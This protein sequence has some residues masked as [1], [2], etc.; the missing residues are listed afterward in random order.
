MTAV[1]APTKKEWE[2]AEK[3]A[4]GKRKQTDS[5]EDDEEA[6]DEGAEGSRGRKKRKLVRAVET[7]FSQSKL[8]VHKGIN[9][10]FSDDQKIAITHQTLRAT[11]S[12]NLPERW[13]SD[14]K[15]MKLF[16][17][18]RSRAMDAIP[19]RSQLGGSLLEKAATKIDAK[20]A[21]QVKGQDV[22]MCTDGWRSNRRDTVGGVT[23]THKFK[24]LLI[25]ILRINQLRK[26]GESLKRQF[27]EMI[28]EAERKL[29]C[30]IIGF[31]TDND[32]GSK[33]AQTL[34]TAA[35]AWLLTFPCCAHQGQLILTDYLRENKEAEVLLGELIDFV[36]WLNSHD[37]IRALFDNKQQ[38]MFGKILA[39]LL[40]NLTCCT[41]HLIAAIRFEFLKAPIRAVILNQ[42]DDIIAAQSDHVRPDQF[43]LALAGLF[44]HF[45]GFSE[46]TTASER[47]LGQRMC[48]H[49]EKRFKELDQVVF[50]LALILNPFAKLSRF[51]DMA[52]ID[53]FKIATELITLFKHINS[54]PPKNPRTAAEQEE[55]DAKQKET[56]QTIN[57]AFMQYLSETGPF[58]SWF[59]KESPQRASYDSLHIC[60]DDPIPFWEMLQTNKA[61]RPLANFALQ[62]LHLVV[63]QAGLEHWFSDFLNKNNKKRN[64]LGLKKMGQQANVQR[65]LVF[66]LQVP[67]RRQVTRYIHEEQKADGLVEERGGR[68]NHT[69]SRVQKLLSVPQYADAILSD[70]DDSDNEGE[71]ISVVLQTSGAW[72]K[73]VAGWQ[74][75]MRE[76]EAISESD[77][78]LPAGV[79]IPPQNSAPPCC[80]APRSWFPTT[81]A[82]LFGG[83]IENPFILARRGRVVSEE[84]LYM[85]LLAAEHSDEEPDAGAQEGSGDDYDG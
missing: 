55:F 20:I 26:D 27:K 57:T 24:S 48:K 38:E 37:K 34:L 21:A 79:P 66:L 53:M 49:I 67:E 65:N 69:D 54:R 29:D 72:R 18:M 7:S 16:I 43:L 8:K 59:E 56:A 60:A 47:G 52:Q 84:S 4:K 11:Q 32:G 58:E 44:L 9:I 22:L 74:A 70:T 3:A 2:K 13:T 17:M 41:T 50:V 80:R 81:L 75:E 33:K 42:G 6:D 10:P 63:N 23:L 19:S 39:Y 76:L 28:D 73:Q 31:L 77:E 35:R 64:R 83:V 45:H 30:N 14:P 5:G 62:L 61:V 71:Q 36:N 82:A 78:D 12:A 15:V 25:S 85:E 68:K 46:H 51:G 40:P 1:A